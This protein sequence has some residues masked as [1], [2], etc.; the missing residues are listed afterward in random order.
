MVFVILLGALARQSF[1]QKRQD[2]FPVLFHS[3]KNWRAELY[4]HPYGRSRWIGPDFYPWQQAWIRIR[5]MISLHCCASWKTYPH[6]FVG[7]RTAYV[8]SFCATPP[9][10]CARP[11]LAIP[12][13][14]KH[15]TNWTYT[16]ISCSLDSQHFDGYQKVLCSVSFHL[17]HCDLAR[18]K[19]CCFRTYVFL[20]V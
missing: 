17:W 2:L 5:I 10:N 1:L 19:D 4:L 13:K 14:R 3:V 18:G 15:Y 20:S 8:S 7:G 11:G 12:V 6:N 16:F 9:N